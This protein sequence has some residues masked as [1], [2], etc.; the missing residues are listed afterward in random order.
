M[1]DEWLFLLTVLSFEFQSTLLV[2]LRGGG[3]EVACNR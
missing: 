3:G 1:S 2:F